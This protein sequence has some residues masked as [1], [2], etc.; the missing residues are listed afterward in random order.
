MTSMA[1]AQVVLWS[2][3]PPEM[4]TVAAALV[5]HGCSVQE[6]RSLEQVRETLEEQP[7]DL[8]VAQ[9]CRCCLEWKDLFRAE[10]LRAKLPPVLL[11]A[12]DYDV[13]LY[14]EAMGSGAFDTI[15]AP[16]DECELIRIAYHALEGQPAMSGKGD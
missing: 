7:V 2:K 10:T 6:L 12:S 4:A 9:M 13:D 8:I 1:G 11:F 3:E 14:L 16:L 5:R 15:S